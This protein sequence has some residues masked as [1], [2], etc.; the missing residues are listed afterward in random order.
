MTL[1][2]AITDD[3]Q[4]S[5]I[6]NFLKHYQQCVFYKMS[7]IKKLENNKIICIKHNT[8]K[9]DYLSVINATNFSKYYTS[10]LF[11]PKKIEILSLPPKCSLVFYP[12]KYLDFY[13]IIQSVL[14]QTSKSYK[15]LYLSSG[16]IL[17]NTDNNKKIFM[18]ETEIKILHILFDKI[19]VKK[20][21]L[22]QS[23]LNFQPGVETRSLESHLSRIRK[24]IHEI[25]GVPDIASKNSIF[26]EI[27]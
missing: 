24:K 1:P 5:P 15:N 20:D 7:K 3:I 4:E 11:V 2:F 18:T 23:I 6:V 9:A 12:I 22:R 26:I 10:I 8:N 25:G 16:S 17:I 19:I 13:K 14:R 27:H 21:L